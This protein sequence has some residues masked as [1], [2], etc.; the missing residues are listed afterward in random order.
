MSRVGFG[1]LTEDPFYDDDG[2]LVDEDGDWED[3]DIVE[4]LN[5]QLKDYDEEYGPY[6]TINS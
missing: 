6:S 2:V 1:I 4:E 5:D 3:Q